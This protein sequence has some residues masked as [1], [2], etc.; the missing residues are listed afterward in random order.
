[1]VLPFSLQLGCTETRDTGTQTTVRLRIQ[2][3]DTQGVGTFEKA[4]PRLLEDLVLP[5]DR[6]L[7]TQFEL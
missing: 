6:S 7:C 4:Q 1:M 2:A 5:E 3:L